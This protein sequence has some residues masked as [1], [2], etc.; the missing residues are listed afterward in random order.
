MADLISQLWLLKPRSAGYDIPGSA[1]RSV[2][3]FLD[4]SVDSS[5]S[6]KSEKE[7]QIE[8]YLTAKRLLFMH[9]SELS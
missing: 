7:T 2:V 9:L 4:T 8:N 5:L 6:M 3:S 1:S